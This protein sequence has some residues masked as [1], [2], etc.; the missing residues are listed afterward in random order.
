MKFRRLSAC[1][2]LLWAALSAQPAAAEGTA[3][4][5]LT[6]LTIEDVTIVS[7]ADVPAGPFTMPGGE[8]NARAMQ[9]PAFCRV[10]ALAAP[11]T[12]SHINLEIWVPPTAAWNGK[13][14][15]VGANAFLGQ[16]SY[17]AMADAL[18]RG[19]AT[20][21]T[22]TGHVGGELTFARGHP[23]KIVDWGHRAQH[24]TAETAKLVV[25]THTGR[26]P[27]RA[28]FSGCDSG[29]HQALK[30]A[31]AYPHDYDGIIAGVPAADRTN[32]IIGYLGTWL[33]THDANGRSLLPQPKI[34]LLAQAVTKACDAMDG[35]A[36]GI[37]DDP[38]RC[39]FEPAALRCMG[40]ETGSCLTQEQIEAANKVYA[41]T[42]NARTGELIFRGWPKGSESLGTAPG[43]GWGGLVN[44][45]EPRR[46]E[47]FRYFVFDDPNWN[48]RSFDFD[49]DVA[50]TRE[51]VGFIDA[52]DADMRP[53]HARGSKLIMY[54]GWVD[55]ILPAEDI[56][57]Y[58]E[59]VSKTMGARTV[60]DFMRFYLIPG[61]SHCRGG[62]GTDV[63]DMLPDLES[64]VEKG[65][66][67]KEVIAS[68][69]ESGKT[70]RTRPLCPYPQVAQWSGKG[71]TDDAANFA[72]RNAGR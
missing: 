68:R 69:L 70:S 30:E 58:Y 26:W 22:D 71:S 7:A 48:Y 16:I 63:F 57:D 12:D 72:C 33:A 40:A 41:G 46:V 51:K 29:G 8:A 20:A 23:E 47:F 54:T 24:V 67:P 21:A 60:Q 62:P 50:F 42:H 19:Y 14:L 36:D 49:K 37:I 15:G 17:D 27:A 25:R 39:P 31:Q 45:P 3:C 11:S 43:Q 55:P 44:I 10:V 64:W 1:A 18:R 28:Y 34:Q 2:G 13:F 6:Q 52:I 5:A 65:V 56:V 4:A 35:I 59:R 66:A 38:R 61:F 32:E 9:L 53:F